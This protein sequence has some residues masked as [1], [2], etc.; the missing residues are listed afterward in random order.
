MVKSQ[1]GE[2]C[3]VGGKHQ[4]VEILEDG[5]AKGSKIPKLRAEKE[6]GGKGHTS[7]NVGRK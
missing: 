6:G 2:D 7:H 4:E 1:W 3:E 5:R